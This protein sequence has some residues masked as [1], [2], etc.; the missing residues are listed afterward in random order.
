MRG[1]QAMLGAMLAAALVSAHA[2]AQPAPQVDVHALFDQAER[3]ARVGLARKTMPVDARPAQP[4]EVVV[5]LIAGEGK[6]TQSPPAK[7][8]DMVVRNRCP[9]TGNEEILVEA[10]KFAE[11]YDGPTG[12]ADAGWQPYRPRGIEMRYFLVREA[13]GAFSFTAPWGEPMVARPGD[14]I[15]R[16]PQDAADTYRI[17]AAAFACTYEILQPAG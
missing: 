5:T 6:E 11:R 1:W 12:P 14:A 15:V 13:D 3:E 16:D 2:G 17:A 4:G 8:G 7:P 9:E 10:A